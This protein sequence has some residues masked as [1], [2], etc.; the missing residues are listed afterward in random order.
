MDEAEKE[1]AFVLKEV[2]KERRDIV[3]SS[4]DE[5]IRL[6]R[7]LAEK[8]RVEEAIIT[9]ILFDEEEA[10]ALNA[11]IADQKKAD[12]A[13]KRIERVISLAEKIIAFTRQ[14][15][16][17]LSGVFDEFANNRQIQLQN[18]LFDLREARDK[19][20]ITEEEFVEKSKAI[21]KKQAELQHKEAVKKKIFDI[22]QSEINNLVAVGQTVASI[23]QFPANVIAGAAVEIAGHIRTAAIAARPIPKFPHG[24]SFLTNGPQAFISGDT[25]NGR[26][27]ITVAQQPGITNNDNRSTENSG[28][29]TF[30]IMANDPIEL[31]NEIEKQGYSLVRNEDL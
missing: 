12:L 19:G 4:G 2:E 6:I 16:D 31:N 3:K 7:E 18:E 20:L 15:L 14:G 22:I 17:D 27:R 30:N 29:V 21:R 1:S 24:G 28:P 5:R 8:L 23:S 11:E 9:Q 13:T 25:P 10:R 26:E